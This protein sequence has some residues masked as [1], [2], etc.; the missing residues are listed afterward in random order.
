MTRSIPL[1]SIIA[2]RRCSLKRTGL[3]GMAFLSRLLL[4]LV[5][6]ARRYSARMPAALMIGAQLG[7]L[8]AQELAELVG[9]AAAASNACVSNEVGHVPRAQQRGE[10]GVEARDDLRRRAGG[11]EERLP[12]VDHGAGQRARSW[13]AASGTKRE[14]RDEVTASGRSWLCRIMPMV[15]GSVTMVAWIWP[16][17]RVDDAQG[18]RRDRARGPAARRPAPSSASARW[19]GEPWPEVPTLIASGRARA[20]A[21]NSA[22]VPAGTFGCTASTCDSV[23]IMMIGAKSRTGSNGRLAVHARIGH[24]RIGRDHDGVAVRAR[25]RDGVEADIAA[26]AAAVLDHE[27]LA[28]TLLQAAPE[29]ARQD[30]EAAAGGRGRDDPDRLRRP[31]LRLRQA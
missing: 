11:R 28:E 17:T 22:K 6:D 24:Q 12:G 3:R 23:A 18:R 8:V 30:V 20:S 27:G 15:A 19:P 13:S 21:T 26:A 5:P 16:P 9:R 2:C 7:D 25:L 4:M 31:A 14:R 29:Q 1:R 10:L